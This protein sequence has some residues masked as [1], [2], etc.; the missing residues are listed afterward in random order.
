M[1]EW[2]DLDLGKNVNIALRDVP[3]S[4]LLKEVTKTNADAE[5]YKK[6]ARRNGYG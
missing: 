2:K 5:E 1:Y 3:K 6:N 4:V